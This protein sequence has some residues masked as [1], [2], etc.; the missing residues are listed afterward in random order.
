MSVELLTIFAGASGAAV[1]KLIDG[2]VQWFLNRKAKKEDN[3]EQAKTD[4]EEKVDA[5]Q[6]GM[7]AMFLDRIQY[8]CKTYLKD[9]EIEIE[10]RRRL[11]IMHDVYHN[12]L[13][14]NGDLD[15]L[16]EQVDDLPLKV[17]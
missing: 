8:L 1:I 13:G 3:I 6:T 2:V 15:S 5:L 9:G 11:H 4:L 12:V 10:D 16:M 14:G 17:R 7:M